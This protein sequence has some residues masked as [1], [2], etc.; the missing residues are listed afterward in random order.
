MNLND[1]TLAATIA[2]ATAD[3][4][5]E[6]DLEARY[7]VTQKAADWLNSRIA[8]LKQKLTESETAL[9]EYREREKIVDAKGLALSG[10]SRQLED[11]TKSLVEVRQKRSEA[12]NAL[13]QV[14]V[15]R[16]SGAAGG[17]ESIPAVIRNQ[18]Y[19]EA[20]K[21]EAETERRVSE[22]SQRYGKEHPR[23]VQA[24]G[25]LKSA[26]E[27]TRRQME[28]IVAGLNKEFEVAR[29]NELAVERNL[30]EAR[31]DIQSLNRKE[32]QLGILERE[33][34][35]SRQV[36]DMFI[37]R[38]KE[39][40]ATNDL[41][42]PVARVVDKA[43]AQDRPVRPKPLLA[44]GV[45][46]CVALLGAIAL[47]LLLERLDNTIKNSEDVENQARSES[48]GYRPASSGQEGHR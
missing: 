38:S 12:E 10:A 46:F 26:K 29:A 34:A 33:V 17:F 41:Q 6:S 14:K 21:V 36:Y 7:L 30:S 48:F 8:G 16:S 13:S 24:E 18:L 22:L 31:G 20:K 42:T 19:I 27:N 45:G 15:L 40:S 37:G 9:Q 39:A 2:N 5:I 25:E 44:A 32:Y 4:Y 3:T 23:M 11:L 47:A 28:T 1:P 35:S 43:V